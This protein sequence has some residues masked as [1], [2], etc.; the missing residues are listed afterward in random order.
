MAVKSSDFWAVT[1]CSLESA[2]R[3]ERTY[4]LR[5]LFLIFCSSCCSA[6]KMEAAYSSE[7]SDFLRSSR[8]YN[9][10][11]DLACLLPSSAGFLLCIHFDLEDGGDIC[12]LN[13][14]LSLDYTALHPEDDTLQCH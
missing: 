5:L 10:E 13:V 12:L 6:L 8:R 3:L 7:T 2:Q 4:R 11:A 9:P 14:R 1:Q